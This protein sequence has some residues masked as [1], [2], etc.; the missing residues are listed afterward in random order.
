MLYFFL[1]QWHLIVEK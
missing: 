1:L